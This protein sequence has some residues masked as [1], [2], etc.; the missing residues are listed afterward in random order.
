MGM[1]YLAL[2][3]DLVGSSEQVVERRPS[4]RRKSAIDE[5]DALLL[6]EG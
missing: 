4:M 5:E 6:V 1:E 2:R 3:K